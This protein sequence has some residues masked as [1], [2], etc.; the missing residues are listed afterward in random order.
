MCECFREK[1]KQISLGTFDQRKFE[2]KYYFDKNVYNVRERV[3]N[4]LSRTLYLFSSKYM[5]FF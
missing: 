1:S 5:F 3:T 4:A 2:K